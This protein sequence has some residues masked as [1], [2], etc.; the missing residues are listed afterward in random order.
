MPHAFIDFDDNLWVCN[1]DFIA[2]TSDNAPN[3]FQRIKGE[4]GS[5]NNFLKVKMVS[6][7]DGLYA[8]THDNTFVS[9]SF[10]LHRFNTHLSNLDPDICHFIIDSRHLLLLSL[11][12]TLFIYEHGRNADIKDG[13]DFTLSQTI[14]DVSSIGMIASTNSSFNT[15]TTAYISQGE[16]YRYVNEMRYMGYMKTNSNDSNAAKASYGYRDGISMIV[17]EDCSCTDGRMTDKILRHHRKKGTE[18]LLRCKIEKINNIVDVGLSYPHALLLNSAGEVYHILS[19]SLCDYNGVFPTLISEL[20]D[21]IIS[22]HNGIWA[23]DQNQQVWL[24]NFS[25]EKKVSVKSCTPV[26]ELPKIKSLAGKSYYGMKR[27]RTT[28]SAAKS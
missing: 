11:T 19:S 12:G 14:E 7:Y 10:G 8:I 2:E 4:V 6:D 9:I 22:V 1:D 27:F 15:M 17:R 23:L 21:G 5:D 16:I 25:T 3:K 13:R 20:P 24:M 26:A 28:K 18:G